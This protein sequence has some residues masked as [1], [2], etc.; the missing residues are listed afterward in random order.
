M[1]KLETAA[2]ALAVALMLAACGAGTFSPSRPGATEPSTSD[3]AAAHS[4]L[5]S[6]APTPGASVE[7][8]SPQ[9]APTP[10]PTLTPL[11]SIRPT[12]GPTPPST[13]S[14]TPKPTVTPTRAPT[15][16]P[17]TDWAIDIS[18]PTRLP[19]QPAKF[20][21]VVIGTPPTFPDMGIDLECE[22]S[23]SR[24][25]EEGGGFSSWAHVGTVRDTTTF[26]LTDTWA[27][28]IPAGQTRTWRV[29]CLTTLPWNQS[30]D[31]TGTATF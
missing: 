30:R 31:D 13:K 9:P 20:K 24:P 12:S 14:P 3:A 10:T 23:W 7:P 26:T 8:G 6:N 27:A 18:T 5:A 28:N 16:A 2:I 29:R 21:G 19:G 11:A 25:P 17:T 15:A 4:D 1:R 22:S